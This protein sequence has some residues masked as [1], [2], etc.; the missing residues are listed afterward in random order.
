MGGFLRFALASTQ[1]SF[2]SKVQA[3]ESRSPEMWYIETVIVTLRR[4]T[5]GETLF[6]FACVCR[7][8]M[9]NSLSPCVHVCLCVERPNVDICDIY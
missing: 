4:D 6:D 9:C 1:M 5:Y 2:V 7:S 8:Y 3:L